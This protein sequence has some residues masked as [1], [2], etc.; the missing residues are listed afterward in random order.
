MTMISKTS[1]NSRQIHPQVNWTKN[2][3][4]NEK[5]EF[6]EL[7]KLSPRI[8]GRLKEMLEE[9]LLSIQSEETNLDDFNDPSWSHKQAFRNGRKA[10]IQ[11][12]LSYLNHL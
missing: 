2:L 12:A 9:D 11:K 3:K 1:S 4:G 6:L 8:L 7:L 10:G 5:E